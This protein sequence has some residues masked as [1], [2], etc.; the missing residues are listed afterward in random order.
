M[1]HWGFLKL[2]VLRTY[3]T[4]V[5]ICVKYI[6][7]GS[8]CYKMLFSLWAISALSNFGMFDF[9]TKQSTADDLFFNCPPK[10]S[11]F[12]HNVTASK[13]GFLCIFCILALFVVLWCLWFVLCVVWLW[14]STDVDVD[15]KNMALFDVSVIVTKPTL[16]L[17]YQADVGSKKKNTM[18]MWSHL[19]IKINCR[20]YG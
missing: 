9:A 14:F 5:C 3:V 6:A 12:M 7:E 4:H 16:T 11:Y 17:I 13:L 10:F 2:H 1:Q 8:V 20:S 19:P 15:K 18:L